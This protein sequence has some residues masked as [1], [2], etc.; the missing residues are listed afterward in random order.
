MR[1]RA[2]SLALL[3]L[4]VSAGCSAGTGL[5]YHD[6]PTSRHEPGSEQWWAE[7]GELPP[8]VRQS[9]YKGK[10]WPA[11]PR[12]TAPKQQFSHIYHSQHYWPLPYTCQ[13]QQAVW[14]MI[15]TQTALGWQEETTLFDHHFEAQ[16]QELNSAGQR[17]LE[18][19]LFHVPET[20]RS[21]YVQ[22]THNEV[23]NAVRMTAVEDA[24]AKF[25]LA[26]EPVPVTLRDCR[27]TG[28]PAAEI[29]AMS[30]MYRES[31][32]TPRLGSAGGGGGA[33]AAG[34]GGGFGAGSAGGGAGGSG[35]GSR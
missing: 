8:G 1:I 27:G 14:S 18:Y 19:I 24:V 2:Q 35:G 29:Q 13:D 28:R 33:G 26:G 25:Q 32:P 10:V 7:K 12:S 5:F 16:G 23:N 6:D 9:N 30:D 17:H 20:R 3:C 21:V 15:D 22:S 11:R 4:S 31:I 34:A